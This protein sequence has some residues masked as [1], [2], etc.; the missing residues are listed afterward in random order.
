M[1]AAAEIMRKVLSE[2]VSPQAILPEGASGFRNRIKQVYPSG[3]EEIANEAERASLLLASRV[4]IAAKDN[5]HPAIVRE[6]PEATKLLEKL[7]PKPQW[8]P[9]QKEQP[10]PKPAAAPTQASPPPASARAKELLARLQ[11]MVG[12]ADQLM[13]TYNAGTFNEGFDRF[14]YHHQNRLKDDPAFAKLV[15]RF[16]YE[17]YRPDALELHRMPAHETRA[18]NEELIKAQGHIDD[19][20][21]HLKTLWPDLF[22]G[23]PWPS[24]P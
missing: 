2:S 21:Q 17:Q 11:T 13:R 24:A 22:A 19:V 7:F 18:V 1:S 8:K 4:V 6:R 16:F 12:V 3:V 15:L 5:N 23:R 10:A 20:A 14:G 9:A